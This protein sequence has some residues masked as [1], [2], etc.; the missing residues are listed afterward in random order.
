MLIRKFQPADLDQVMQIW[1]DGN[2]QAH[3]FID[4]S[5]WDEHY[6]AV[7]EALQ[8]AEVIV[9][10]RNS[11]IVGFAGM[12]DDYLAG[13]FVQESFQHQG[14]GGQLLRAIK[15]T[16]P[17]ISLNVYLTNKQAVHFYQGQGFKIINEQADETGQQEYLMNWRKAQP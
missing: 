4:P 7:R 15:Q 8:Q 1:L 3:P 12:Q 2:R 9:A 10:E 6:S 17:S 16:H 11:Q 5:Y 14:I 13:I